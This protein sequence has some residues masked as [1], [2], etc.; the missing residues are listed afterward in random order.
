MNKNTCK[1]WKIMKRKWKSKKKIWMRERDRHT[2]K[3][4]K[5]YIKKRVNQDTANDTTGKKA[6][7]YR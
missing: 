6:R 3:E 1:K 5:L 4:V 2:E 7:N